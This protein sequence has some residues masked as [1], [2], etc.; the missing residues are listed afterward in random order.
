M[1]RTR[2]ARRAGAGFTLIELLVC[3]AIIG[4]LSAIAY[5]AYTKYVVKSNR[6]AAEAHLVELAQAESQYLA[7]TRSYADSVSNLGMTTPDAV[8]SKYTITI[9]ASDGP[10]AT[11]LITASPKT[12]SSQAGDGDLTINQ[13]GTRTPG[14]K[15]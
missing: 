13:A 11:F 8:A 12:T 2:T 4:I 1:Y 9:T 7:D 15:W 10:P 3:V 14:S 5:P 6:G